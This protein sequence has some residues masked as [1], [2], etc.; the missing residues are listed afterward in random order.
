MSE[1][2]DPCSICENYT[3]S[4]ECDIKEKCP[5][6]AMKVENARLKAENSRL[7]LDMSYM[8][9]PLSIGDRHE[10]GG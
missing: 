6:E 9:N 10:M 1:Y 2:K 5:I 7:R 3:D 4:L 8:D